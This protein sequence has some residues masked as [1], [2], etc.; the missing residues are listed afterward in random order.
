[1]IIS[2][3]IEGENNNGAVWLFPVPADPN[4]V[5][6]DVVKSLPKLHG[7]EISKKAKSNLNDIKK[8]LQLT[9]IYTVPFIVFNDHYVGS[10]IS[11]NILG[12]PRNI[13][14]GIEQDVIVYEHL[15]KEGITSEIITAKT[16]NGLYDYLKNKGLKIE[17]GSI[18]VLDNYIG[19]EYSFVALWINSPE[20]II[21]MQYI[22]DNLSIYFSSSNSYPKFFN[23][24]NNLK[25]KHS[26][27]N[28]PCSPYDYLEALNY[29]KSQQGEIV[30]QE[31]TQIIQNDLSIITD[32]YKRNLTNLSN[33]K[34]VFVTFPTKDLYFPLLPTSVY[35]SKTIP[36]TIK[37][38]G[39][40][41]P[42]VFEEIKSYT[43]TEY[44]IAS[45]SNLADELKNFY[46]GQSRNIKYYTKIEIKAPSKFLTDDLWINNQ[47]PVKTYYTIFVAKHPIINVIILLI[48]SSIIAGILAGLF[49]FKE[50]RKNIVKLGLIGLSNCLSILGLL[51]TVIFINTKEKNENV[52]PILAEIKR[53]GYFWRRILVIILLLVDLPLLVISVFVISS[54]IEN[55]IEKLIVMDKLIDLFNQGFY[56]SIGKFVVALAPVVILV[57][58]LIIRRIKP[59]DKNLF[60]Q[61]K[62]NNYSSWSFQPKDKMKITFVPIFSISFLIISWLLVKL[63]EFTV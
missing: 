38:I 54:F 30:L 31:L 44:Y 37:L 6:I 27:F 49:V 5:V 57:F 47:A 28:Q 53:K 34:G 14:K 18:S 8:F 19:K 2:V 25:Q 7:E 51:A 50:L 52:K 12:T 4:K 60:K 46:N 3:G 59:E 35:G 11:G 13:H 22:K 63:I 40:V 1:M 29:L 58:S 56:F 10:T 21:S 62:L 9:Q 39:H 20:K 43:K 45:Y 41:S 48:L 26:E 24:L 16:A 15:E 42:K 17:N 55:F 36:A 32:V 61:L 23:T 33:Q